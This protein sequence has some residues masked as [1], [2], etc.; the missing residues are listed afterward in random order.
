VEAML[1]ADSD[2]RIL[3]QLEENSAG[4]G[5]DKSCLGLLTMMN[6]YAVTLGWRFEVHSMH[7]EIMIVTTRAVLALEHRSGEIV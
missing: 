6:D 3:T 1:A 2:D 7:S 4:T 5:S